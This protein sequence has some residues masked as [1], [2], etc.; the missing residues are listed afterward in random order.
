MTAP[1]ADGEQIV[2]AMREAVGP[3]GGAASIGCV[4]P[5]GTGTRLGDEVESQALHRV[6]GERT[7]EVPS[8]ASR[9]CS[10]MRAERRPRSARSRAR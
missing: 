5:H 9:R 7:P 3:A 4:I 2:R 8:T 6:F 10:A 1:H